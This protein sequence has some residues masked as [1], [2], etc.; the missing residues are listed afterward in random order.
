MKNI[1]ITGRPG[2]G[3]SKL[4]L[5]FNKLGIKALGIDEVE[6]LCYWVDSKTGQKAYN[7]LPTQEWLHAH[8]W[9]CNIKKL[10]ELLSTN[11]NEILLVTGVASNQD[12]Y[13]NLFDKIFLLK[14]TQ[15]TLTK[16]LIQRQYEDGNNFGKSEEER[17]YINNVFSDFEEGLERKGAIVI[18][19][20]QP[21][22]LVL[23]DI[24]SKI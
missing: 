23:N 9:V 5:E 13:L 14:S 7:H 18:D 19:S 17:V 21:I 2:T 16:R 4:L 1:Y 20:D 11:E 24:L 15:E 10:E 6:G 3:K 22:S 12:S 8:E